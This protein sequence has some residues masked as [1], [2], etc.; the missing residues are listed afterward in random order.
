MVI[1]FCAKIYK[2]SIFTKKMIFLTFI[3]QRMDFC[4]SLIDQIQMCGEPDFFVILP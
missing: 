3:V 2:K 4:E 1:M